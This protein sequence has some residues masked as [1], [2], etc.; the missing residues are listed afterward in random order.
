MDRRSFYN[1]GISSQY[2]AYFRAIAQDLTEVHVTGAQV[3]ETLAASMPYVWG[4]G[5]PAPRVRGRDLSWLYAT[6][7]AE[8]VTITF[9][10]QPAEL[11]RFAVI[12]AG[13]ARLGVDRGPDQ[14]LPL[15]VPVIE[16]VA[17]PTATPLPPT[18]TPPGP[19]AT[20]PPPTPRPSLLYLPSLWRLHCRPA[21]SDIVLL[22]DVS[23]SMTEPV[24]EGLIKLDAAQD[25]A[26]LF[27]DALDLP[28]DHAAV[29]A[30]HHDARV[31]QP[32]SGDLGALQTA[33]ARLHGLVAPGS[34]LDRGLEEAAALL[35][36]PGRRATSQPVVVL[37]TDGR[38]DDDAQALTMAAGLRGRGVALYTIG[39]GA[40]VDG[41]L[42]AALAGEPA[43]YFLSPD[44][45][46][47][48]AIYLDIAR[49]AG[50][51]GPGAP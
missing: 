22:L 29:V 41:A 17:V 15:P 43:R 1:V 31:V 12:D 19:T 49:R 47:L 50:C 48:A 35:T 51:A 2:P 44:G 14:V 3:Q 13:E 10:I 7:P 46:D 4:S 38:A 30:F 11:G 45:A 32:L 24:A 16:V 6:W 37:L 40:D 20:P 25:A 34:R 28:T 5:I 42:L 9:G 33:L 26:S 36:D 18:V 27:V 23:S 21:A 8:G 39:L